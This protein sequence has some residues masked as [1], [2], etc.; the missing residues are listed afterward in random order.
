M[1][2][3]KYLDML[4]YQDLHN[5]IAY[6]ATSA[7]LPG[8]MDLDKIAQ[9][10]RLILEGIG[11]DLQRPGIEET[12]ERVARMYAEICGGLYQDPKEHIKIVPAETH[13]EVILV[14][15]ISIFSLCE[16]HL[17]PFFGTAHI[18]YIP[19]QGRIIGLSKLARVA[20]TFARRPQLQE[21]LTTQIADALFEGLQ[22]K[23]VITMIEC[24]HMCMAMR[25]VRKP[26]ATTITSATR[27]L[28]N[29]D[30][31]LRSEVLSLINR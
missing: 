1:S 5:N 23:A 30:K 28:F 2:N 18:A 16:H 14:K 31:Q 3:S 19:D 20:E 13:E 17:V 24:Q 10:V 27:G 11:E 29:T 21:R 9:G 7:T 6:R 12:P 8:G 15:D 26:G 22:A 4:D 25:G